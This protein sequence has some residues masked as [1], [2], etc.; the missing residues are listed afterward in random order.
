MNHIQ[1]TKKAIS[2]LRKVESSRSPE[3]FGG[4]VRETVRELSL[5]HAGEI[6]L[7]PSEEKGYVPKYFPKENSREIAS[8]IRKEFIDE[9]GVMV[10]NDYF[11]Q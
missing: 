1:H 9:F 7:V 10:L 11:S 5:M 6:E 3:A 2:N 4:L 8:E